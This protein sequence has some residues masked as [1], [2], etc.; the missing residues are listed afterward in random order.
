GVV[1]AAGGLASAVD[2][3]GEEADESAV[4]D[5]FVDLHRR[6][7]MAVFGGLEHQRRFHVIRPATL[8]VGLQAQ[9][10]QLNRVQRLQA[11]F[12]VEREGDVQFA[13]AGV[14][15]INVVLQA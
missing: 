7:S 12:V 13:V 1:G 14:G 5:A 11:A 6:G 10:D 4:G 8:A 3:L 2:R 15:D 9:G